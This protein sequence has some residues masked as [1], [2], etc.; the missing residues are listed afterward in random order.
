MLYV[1]RYTIFP[2]NSNW[3]EFLPHQFN[4]FIISSARNLIFCCHLIKIKGGAKVDK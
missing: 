2:K 4:D 3:I 1:K